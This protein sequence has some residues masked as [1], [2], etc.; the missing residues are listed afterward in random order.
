MTYQVPIN[1]PMV[2]AKQVTVN[3]ENVII[4][5]DEGSCYVIEV[6]PVASGVPMGELFC[7][8]IRFCMTLETKTTCRLTISYGVIFLKSTMMKSVIKPNVMNALSD[9]TMDYAKTLKMIIEEQKGL[10]I[11]DD[12]GIEAKLFKNS[13]SNFSWASVLAVLLCISLLFNIAQFGYCNKPCYTNLV[14]SKSDWATSF[15]HSNKDK[16]SPAYLSINLA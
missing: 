10:A 11:T 13:E 3:E 5:Q 14:T 2:R 16:I 12:S 1:N 9:A 15:V 8:K 7:P 6:S 4:Q